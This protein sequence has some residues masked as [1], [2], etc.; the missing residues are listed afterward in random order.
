MVEGTKVVEVESS[1]KLSASLGISDDRMVE[2]SSMISTLLL[3]AKK[4]KTRVADIIIKGSAKLNHPNELAFF[5]YM[6]AMAKTEME[7]GFPM[8]DQVDSALQ[9][10]GKDGFSGPLKLRSMDDLKKVLD[11]LRKLREDSDND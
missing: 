3:A 8:A 10:L 2:I 6:L 4:E 9:N 5:S 11:L 7:K 1:D